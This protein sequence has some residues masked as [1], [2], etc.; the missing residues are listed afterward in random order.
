MIAGRA[1]AGDSGANGHELRAD[2]ARLGGD[3]A[4]LCLL[5]RGRPRLRR[6]AVAPV[7]IPVP[8]RRGPARDRAGA[9]A[10]VLHAVGAA[11]TLLVTA[12]WLSSSYP[13]SGG[14]SRRGR[15][16][17]ALLRVLPR[18][19]LLAARLGRP[20]TG[21]AAQAHFAGPLLLAAFPVLAA[22]EPAFVAPWPLMGAL[23]GAGRLHRLAGRRRP[24]RVALLHRGV[25]RD[26]HA[27]GVVGRAPDARASR[28]RRRHLHRVRPRLA[29][30]SGRRPPHRRGRS[31]RRGAAARCC[32]SG[33]ACCSSSR[34]DR[35]RPPRS[36]R[37][38][39]CSRSPTPRSSSRARPGA[40]RSSRRSAASCRG[41]C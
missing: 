37:W 20:F 40:C 15:L 29:R 13:R 22:I 2:G 17:G 10:G 3:A 8:H 39:C 18:A 9:A 21:A 33:C 32:C 6:A 41:S 25:L 7:R 35:W 11:A 27:G 31:S 34:S 36:G 19:P 30:R 12:T 1:R 26:C 23:L 5:P 24:T 28:Y 14:R 38:R 4:A 16:H